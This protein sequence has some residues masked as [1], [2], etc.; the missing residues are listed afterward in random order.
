MKKVYVSLVS[1]LGWAGQL[2][3]RGSLV[4][5][6]DFA[7]TFHAM[8]QNHAAAFKAAAEL[9]AASVEHG[10]ADYEAKVSIFASGSD[11]LLV[12]I[13]DVFGWRDRINEPAT[14]N[15]LN[16]TYR[17]P[18]PSDQLEHIPAAQE[19]RQIGERLQ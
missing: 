3:H 19:R 11:L 5:S 8:R 16:W 15:D 1:S 6:M 13:P 18:W 14:V 9:A 17:L 12:T 7:L 4:H 2:R 10:F